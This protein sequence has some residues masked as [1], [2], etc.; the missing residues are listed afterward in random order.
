M[1][2]TGFLA[3]CVDKVVATITAAN[4]VAVTD[5]RNARP[6]TVLV[7]PPSADTFNNNITNVTIVLNVL[8]APP[9]NSDAIDYLM[10]TCETL[11]QT[12]MAV[13]GPIDFG[14]ITIGSQDLPTY[15]MTVRLG[16]RRA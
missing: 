16:N 11:L 2:A 10:T 1:A 5:P 4:L 12:D 14:I 13:V 9:G 8:G 6:M 7:R 15:T 3:Q